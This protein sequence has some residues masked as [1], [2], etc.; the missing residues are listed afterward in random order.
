MPIQPLL[1]KG[2]A[3]RLLGVHEYARA[4]LK[5]K[6]APHA[7]HAG[8][9]DSLLDELEA[10]GFLSEQRAAESVVHRRAPRLGLARI[11]QELRAKG[12]SP[13]LVQQTLA[14]LQPSEVARARQVWSHKFSGQPASGD[15]AERARQMRFLLSRGFSADVVR[16][17]VSGTEDDEQRALE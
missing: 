13:D 12:L 17:V 4:E 5:R 3:L 11:R 2:R 6:L 15:A 10:K 8:Q 7:E 16:R 9:I 14:G 1:L